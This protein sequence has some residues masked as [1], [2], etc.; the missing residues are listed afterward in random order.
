MFAN[1][2]LIV[3]CA[4]MVW[5]AWK[6]KQRPELTPILIGVLILTF[7]VIGG[8]LFFQPRPDAGRMAHLPTFFEA[9]G[10][11]IGRAVSETLPEGGDILV[12]HPDLRIS[13]HFETIIEAQVRGLRKGLAD[14]PFRLVRRTMDTD[15][16]GDMMAMGYFMDANTLQKHVAQAPDSQAVVLMEILFIATGH[17]PWP[18]VFLTGSPDPPMV[19]GLLRQGLIE[20]AILVRED[21]DWGAKPSDDMSLDEVFALRYELVRRP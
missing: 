16:D 11:Q 10:Y 1:I 20:A 12:I 5:L 8:R 19:E 14:K 6:R 4:A 17:G 18:P 9:T 3:L 7:V 21:A 13:R 15:E 2:L